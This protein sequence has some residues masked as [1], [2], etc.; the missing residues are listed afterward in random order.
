M[1][2]RV[3]AAFA[4]NGGFITRP[5]ALDAGLSVGHIN[6]AISAGALVPLRR[7]VYADP[8]VWAALDRFRGR[9]QLRARAAL[10]VMQ[11]RSVLSHDSAALFL[12]MEVLDSHRSPVH[13][14]RDGNPRAWVKAGVHHHLARFAPEQ[15]GR[16][17]GLEVLDPA[18]TAVDIAR[19]SGFPAGVVACDSA[20]RLGVTRNELIAA[21]SIMR[22]WPGVTHARAAVDFADASAANGG[23]SLHRILVSELGLE[24]EI[25]PQ[26][27]IRTPSGLRIVDL[28]VGRHFFEFHGTDKLVPVETGGLSLASSRAAIRSEL[29]RAT[30]LR[31]L[32]FGLSDTYW[33][34]LRGKPR[35]ATL[36]RLAHEYAVTRDRFGTEVPSRMLEFAA[37]YRA[38]NPAA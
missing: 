19:D 28:R 33:A 18:R 8:E 3:R 15:V 25:D 9:P 29:A 16:V 6:S 14:T 21:Y 1:N 27:P 5:E 34:D 11:R 12:G 30:E 36:A 2:P 31:D 23:E 26:F 24:E 4:R 35:P 7:G 22:F 17:D 10:A 20:M 32:G 13:V 38:A 37:Q